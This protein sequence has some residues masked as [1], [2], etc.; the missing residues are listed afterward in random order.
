MTAV[1]KKQIDT[2]VKVQQ[3]EIEAAKLNAYLKKL[4]ARISS[5]EQQ[6][7]EFIQS[8]EDD[9]AAIE[10]FNKQYRALEADVQLNLSKIQKSQE[11][12]RSV[13]T[14]KEYQ[15]S[16]KEIDDIQA[17]NSKLEDE[18]L[19]L[20]EKIET[21]E[22]AIKDRRQHYAEIVD[23]S[24]RQKE[25]IERDAA[26]HEENLVELESR[27]VAIAAQLDAG[28]LKLFRQ[29]KAKQGDLVAIVAVQDAVCQGCNMN[30]P[31]QVYNE[32]QRCDSLKYCPSCFRIIYW[33]D[34]D[35]RSE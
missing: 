35:E 9:E 27:R 22:A 17:A 18:M 8:V 31:P 13:K 25:S 5:L 14:N 11:K 32:L 29:V 15:S 16:L 30:I 6:L 19:E 23:E 24:N 12:L 10:G 2:L 7:E 4:P 20:L 1:A 21:A 33:Q 26:R 34:Q 3:I 28:L